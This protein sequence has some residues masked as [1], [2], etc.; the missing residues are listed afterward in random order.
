MASF[1]PSTLIKE[2]QNGGMPL[3]PL[4]KHSNLYD[5]MVDLLDPIADDDPFDPDY[6]IPDL[7][8]KNFPVKMTPTKVND[9]CQ[10]EWN[11]QTVD[12]F[13]ATKA[14]ADFAGTTVNFADV[15]N[16]KSWRGI[17]AGSQ[18]VHVSMAT[19]LATLATVTAITGTSLTVDVKLDVKV[20]DVLSRWPKYRIIGDCENVVDDVWTGFDATP[21]ISNFASIPVSWRMD[22]CEL[23]KDY[24]M[25][26]HGATVDDWIKNEIIDPMRGFKSVFAQAMLFGTNTA[27]DGLK[28]SQTMSFITGIKQAQAKVNPAWDPNLPIFVWDFKDC[29]ANADSDCEII[30]IF[31]ENVIEPLLSSGA[32][33]GGKPISAWMN[34]AQ[35]KEM[36][37]LRHAIIDVFAPPAIV[38]RNLDEGDSGLVYNSFQLHSFEIGGTNFEYKYSETLTKLYKTVPV[39]ILFPRHFVSLKQHMFTGINENMKAIV[40]QGGRPR[41]EVI[42]ASPLAHM[43]SGSTECNLYKANFTYALCLYGLTTG[44]YAVV[45]NMMSKQSC[46]GASCGTTF[47]NVTPTDQVVCDVHGNDCDGD[48]LDDVTGNPTSA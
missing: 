47:D 9:C 6:S 11:E 44:A 40:N 2:W 10:V 12:S 15:E 37:R 38:V 35:L 28:G 14:T 48:G 4:L 30:E 13:P 3:Y 41:L 26:N 19:G 36:R 8:F 21:A 18:L 23:N 39:M 5:V 27:S 24:E 1:N 22:R 7:V 31:E 25:Y 45:Y 34:H 16:Y 33:V 43:K 32:Y 29:C 17:T 46:G 20:G 42:D